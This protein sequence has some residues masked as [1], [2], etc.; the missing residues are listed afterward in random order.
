LVENYFLDYELMKPEDYEYNVKFA[1]DN[2]DC[3]I[4]GFAIG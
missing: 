3:I 2:P 1:M 4:Y